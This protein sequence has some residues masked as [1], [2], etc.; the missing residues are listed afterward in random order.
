VSENT[1]YRKA[2]LARPV[3]D[4]QG[5][6]LQIRGDGSRTNWLPIS[7]AEFQAIRKILE[8]SEDK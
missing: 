3:V 5:V 1:E 7:P 4:E 6:I 2:Q 8:G